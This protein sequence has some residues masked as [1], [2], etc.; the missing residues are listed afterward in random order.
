MRTTIWVGLASVAL[1]A[2]CSGGNGM[3]GSGTVLVTVGDQRIT[4]GDLEQL[5]KV[6][7]PQIR[8]QLAVP[9]GKRQIVNTLV[10]RELLYNASLA[11]NLRADPDLQTQ[12]ALHT[13]S[14][15]AQAALTKQIERA[16]REYYDA[17]PQEFETVPLSHL[18]IKFGAI[19]P[20]P[21]QTA[22]DRMVK[23]TPKTRTEAEA[24]AL[25]NQL[26]E[27]ITN[28]EP[29]AK[30][31]KDASDDMATRGSGGSLGNVWRKE[32]RLMRQGLEELLTAAFSAQPTT[33]VGPI[34]ATDGYH[35]LQIN[36]APSTRNF[37]DV[38]S[39]LTQRLAGKVR[40][41]YLAKLRDGTRVVYVDQA[42]AP[43]SALPPAARVPTPKQP[44]V[45]HA[46]PP[47]PTEKSPTSPDTPPS[48]P[49]PAHK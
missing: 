38:V 41:E 2:G 25:A 11:A 7:P 49:V 21:G 16:A 5:T 47:A 48:A 43:T 10:E 26:K 39:T 9:G 4:E 18:L 17:N 45:P 37:D 34:K 1:F 33:V 27:R 14:L 35:L 8:Q 42:L 36:A 15:I 19:P 46:T 23:S 13:R 32:P 40:E 44:G 28:G 20:Q 3:S 12:I 24:V 22:L 31:A 29:F 6:G 30:V